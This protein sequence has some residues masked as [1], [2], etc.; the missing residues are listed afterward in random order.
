MEF[1]WDEEKNAGNIAKHAIDFVRAIRIFEG[2]VFE[3]ST[4]RNHE[5]RIKAIGLVDD[6][7]I[8]VVYVRRGTVRR[9]ISARRAHR[10]ERKTYREIYPG[11]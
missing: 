8:C 6:L 11:G 2:N 1:E 5:E 3:S 9:I 4:I 10:N 7:E